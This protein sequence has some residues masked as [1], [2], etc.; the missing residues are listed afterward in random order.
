MDNCYWC[1]LCGHPD[2]YCSSKLRKLTIAGS[3]SGRDYVA[4]FRRLFGLVASWG[5]ESFV[6][7]VVLGI[8]GNG[9]FAR[10]MSKNVQNPFRRL[11]VM[12]LWSKKFRNVL[13]I[14]KSLYSSLLHSLWHHNSRKLSSEITH[15]LMIPRAVKKRWTGIARAGLLA[16]FSIYVLAASL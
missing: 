13:W 4:G 10:I 7:E 3:Q 14:W 11:R 9:C 12:F 15:W 8:S 2:N 16:L 1:L 5:R 6:R